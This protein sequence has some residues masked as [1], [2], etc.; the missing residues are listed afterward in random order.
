MSEPRNESYRRPGFT[1]PGAARAAAQKNHQLGTAHR[2]T[3]A[4]ARRARAQVGQRQAREQ[5]SHARS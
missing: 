4:T 5:E 3:S 2:W 1:L